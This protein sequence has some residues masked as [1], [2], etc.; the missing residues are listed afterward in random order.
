MGG[1]KGDNVTEH[2]PSSVGHESRAGGSQ[3]GIE[4]AD[5]G[6]VDGSRSGWGSGF[7]MVLIDAELAHGFANLGEDAFIRSWEGVGGCGVW[8]EGAFRLHGGVWVAVE[9]DAEVVVIGG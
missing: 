1:E 6:D 7:G 5:A 3:K 2:E 8:E 4:G 9:A